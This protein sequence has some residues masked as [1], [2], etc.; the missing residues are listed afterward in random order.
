MLFRCR[1]KSLEMGKRTYI[2]GILNMTPDSFS[3]GGKYNT[4]EKGIERALQMI[5]EGADIIDVGGESTR[6]GHTPVDEEEEMRR[7][8]PVIEKLSKISNVI[9]SVDTMKSNVALRALEAGAHIVNDVWGLQRDPKMAEVVTKYHAGVIMMHNSNVAEYEDVVQDIIKFLQKS[10]EIG[11]KAGIDKSQMAVDPG[12][13]FG[14]TLDHNLEV[15]NRLEELKIL[16]LPLLLGTSRKSMI[17]K[18]L[19][20]DVD[21]RLEGTAATVAV[22]IAKGVDIVRVHDIKQM[23]RVAKMTDAMVRR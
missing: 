12:I 2:M 1:D 17:G 15:M 6:P 20:L 9:I 22:G 23:L 7:V 21:D 4:L 8:V 14:K 19:N 5:E 3:D 16:G 10:I 11:E 18:V 13:G